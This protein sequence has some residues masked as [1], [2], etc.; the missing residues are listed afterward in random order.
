MMTMA[1]ESWLPLVEEN[2]VI[3]ANTA[4][5]ELLIYDIAK[6]TAYYKTYTSQL[7]PNAKEINFNAQPASQ[8][9]FSEEMKKKDQQITFQKPIYNPAEEVYYR[10]AKTT[11]QVNDD[12]TKDTYYLTVFDKD[13]N[14]IGE[15]A[16]LPENFSISTLFIK[17]G[18]LLSFIN[19]DD[20][21]GFVVMNI[22]EQ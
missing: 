21:M 17:D 22:Q 2:R 15:T 4:M 10:F 14:M 20:E 9:A 8:E 7:S 13:L 5:N 1:G 12:L 3:Y 19:I 16:E 6:D 11:T 18:K